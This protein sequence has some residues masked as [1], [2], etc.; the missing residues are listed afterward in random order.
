MALAGRFE[1]RPAKI[2]RAQ[3]E[4]IMLGR[5]QLKTKQEKEDH[6]REKI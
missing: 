1:R 2:V 5:W 4:N 3:R 6:G